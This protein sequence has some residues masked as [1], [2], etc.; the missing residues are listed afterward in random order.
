[1]ESGITRSLDLAVRAS[2]RRK[3]VCSVPSSVLVIYSD[4][5]NHDV[6]TE[7]GTSITLRSRKGPCG[8]ANNAFSCG[9]KVPSTDFYLVDG[10][11]TIGNGEEWYAIQKPSGTAQEDIY[12]SKHDIGLVVEWRG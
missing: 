9:P 12:T 7:S 11:L 10:K 8:I 2:R 4:E 5:A 3:M 1:M 6:S